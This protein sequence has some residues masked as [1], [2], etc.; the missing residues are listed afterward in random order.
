MPSKMRRRESRIARAVARPPTGRI[1]GSRLPCRTVAGRRSLSQRRGA[2]AGGGDRVQLA[3][4][5][6]AAVGAVVGGAGQLAEVLL[7]HRVVGRADDAEDLHRVLDRR[8]APLAG[9]REERSQR[10]VGRHADPAVAGRRHD[11]DQRADPLR[12][13]D[14]D[15]LGDHAAHRGADQVR[16]LD[17]EM[18]HQ[19]DRVH[20]PCRAAD[21]AP[22]RGARA[23]CRRGSATRR[24]RSWSSGRC[25]GCRNGRRGS[26]VSASMRAELLV[27][28][29]HLRRQAHDQEQRLAL[30]IADLLV[31]ELDPVGGGHALL[32]EDC[33]PT[34]VPAVPATNLPMRR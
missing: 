19:P 1:S 15:G 6:G 23:A 20:R 24:C 12:A 13:L 16:R 30:R 3:G 11:R 25:R 7:V 32:A 8:L 5:A 28:A 10:L 26:R 14:R 9:P 27:P 34:M 22:C 31:G 2:V 33:H 18:V 29:Q 21:T 17:P 4:D